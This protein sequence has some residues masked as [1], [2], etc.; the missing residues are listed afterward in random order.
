MEPNSLK[1]ETKT[2]TKKSKE[3]QYCGGITTDKCHFWIDVCGTKIR[4][5][6]CFFFFFFGFFLSLDTTLISTLSLVIF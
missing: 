5:F 2:K 3:S 6:V 1:K 4:L